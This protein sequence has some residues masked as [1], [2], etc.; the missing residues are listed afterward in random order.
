VGPD[1]LGLGGGGTGSSRGLTAGVSN[2]GGAG[3]GAH[4]SSAGVAG[5]S[6]VAIIRYLT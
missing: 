6:G 4:P 5:G 1:R 3:G 2:T